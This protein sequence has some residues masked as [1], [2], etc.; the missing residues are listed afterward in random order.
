[1][2]DFPKTELNTGTNMLSEKSKLQSI[3][4]MYAVLPKPPARNAVFFLFFYTSKL[5]RKTDIRYLNCDNVSNFRRGQKLLGDG[6]VASYL[7]LHYSPFLQK[8]RFMYHLFGTNSFD[9][10]LTHQ[11]IFLNCLLACCLPP[12]RVHI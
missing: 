8:E 11:L 5:R 1:M 7:W 6:Q 3:I 2:R 9:F 12:C 10:P 4:I